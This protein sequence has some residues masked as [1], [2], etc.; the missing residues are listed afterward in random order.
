M[1]TIDPNSAQAALFEKLGLNKQSD[2]QKANSDKLG[3]SDFLKLMTTQLQN[4]DPFAPMDNGDFIAQMAQFS[5]VTGIQDMNASLGKLVEEFDQARI[6]TA[7]N[8]LGH[9][10]LVP[11][12]IGR[13]DDEGELHGVLDLP[14]A[15]ISTQL[16]YVDADTNNSLFKEDLGPKAAGLVGF[17]WSDIP[18]EILA[19]NKRIKIEAL[20]DTGN[21][22][23]QLSPSIYSKVISASVGTGET[24]QV[25]LNVEDYGDL[26][27]SSAVNFR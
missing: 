15:T 24:K 27:V 26:D 5:T 3:Q 7:S 11:G 22:P 16:N 20:I 2:A 13:P 1:T 18:E 10:V 17:K 23:E 25:L 9:S 14:E 19:S 12:N 6:A 4:Q 21:G 8:L